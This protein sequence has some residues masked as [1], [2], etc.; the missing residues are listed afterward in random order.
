MSTFLGLIEEIPG[1]SVDRFDGDNLTSSVFF[2]SHFHQD[3]MEGLSS[4]FFAHLEEYNKHIYCSPITK[5]FLES[6]HNVKSSCV[7]GIDIDTP[8]VIEYKVESEGEILICVTCI[9]AG[10]CPGSVMFLF[11]RNDTSILYTGDFRVNPIDFPKLKALHYCQNKKLLPRTFT[12]VYLDTTFLS[13]EY[14]CFPTRKEG[15]T[16]LNGV[17]REWL[18]KN[19]R[20][21]VILKCS[22]RYSSEYLFVE[23]SKELKMKVHVRDNIYRN[24]CLI[25]ELSRHVTNEAN[26]TPIH[27][28]TAK[29]YP[30]LYCRQDV[31]SANILTIV[32]ST[33]RWRNKDTSI[34][35][36]WDRI[37]K[38]TFNICYSMHA[39][40]EELKAFVQYFNPL[41][42]HPCVA[43]PAQEKEIYSLLDE[44]TKTPDKKETVKRAYT[45]DLSSRKI[46]KKPPFT[47]KYFSSDDDSS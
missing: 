10:H 30:L 3:H 2:L 19:P 20:N 17:I 12:K 4:T 35:G 45:F 43:R 1:I 26:S 33:L 38:R 14:P 13:N 32:P 6:A 8:I 39:S 29:N 40:L 16:K 5:V 18:S 23:L 27:A 11:E 25:G 24:Y 36:E 21:V 28:C 31:T 42:V 46:A 47:S 15:V 41:K 34:V 7:K 37:E 44:I 9:S 22:A